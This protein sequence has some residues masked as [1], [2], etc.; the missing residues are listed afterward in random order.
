[1][2][3]V[4][5]GYNNTTGKNYNAEKK[6]ERRGSTLPSL[7][8]FHDRRKKKEI[9]VTKKNRKKEKCG[10]VSGKCQLEEIYCFD[11]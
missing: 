10:W 11:F 2:Q 3:K 7:Q 8:V 4:I 9:T 1:M 6:R 5:F